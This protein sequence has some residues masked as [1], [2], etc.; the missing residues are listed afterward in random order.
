MASSQQEAG[1]EGV[2][3]ELQGQLAPRIPWRLVDPAAPRLP[4]GMRTTN[5]AIAI[6]AVVARGLAIQALPVLPYGDSYG[7]LVDPRDL[8]KSLW[9]PG[10]QTTLAALSYVTSSPDA[11]RA[12]TALQGVAAALAAGALAVAVLGERARLLTGLAVAVLPTFVLTST[13]L[14]QE[15]LFLWAALLGLARLP[16]RPALAHGLVAFA[17]L[18]RYEAWVIA[19]VLALRALRRRELGA[20]VTL[21]AVPVLWVRW[22]RGV[23]PEGVRSLH[24]GISLARLWDRAAILGQLV[25]DGGAVAIGLT[26]VVGAFLGG[27]SALLLLGAGL[28]HLVWLAVLDPYSAPDHPRQAHIPLVILALLASIAV[29]RLPHPALRVSAAILLLAPCWPT[30][31]RIPATYVT[32]TEPLANAA[33]TALRGTLSPDTRAIVLSSGHPSNPTAPPDECLAVRAGA[34][35]T[36]GD[37]LCDSDST[38]P[39]LDDASLSVL[40]RVGLYTAWRPA[41]LQLHSSVGAGWTE[42]AL[43]DDLR[44]WARSPAAAERIASSL[45]TVAQPCSSA[46]EAPFRP[47]NLELQGPLTLREHS[48]IALYA[49][50]GVAWV[51]PAAGHLRVW[52]C[53]TPAGGRFPR[54]QV[55]TPSGVQTFETTSTVR[56]QDVG[57][58]EA[59]EAVQITFQDDLVDDQGLDRNVFIAGW[60]VRE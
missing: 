36:R 37:I 28:I 35:D 53:G 43:R 26:A 38:L 51:A 11:F 34:R 25:L 52:L 7:R 21:L 54:V 46:L 31:A 58:V 20:S 10:Y 41:E 59:G 24:L 19:A 18:V 33:G 39:R 14:Y 1:D 45:S 32:G 17:C 12:W 29:R 42:V 22:S 6:V 15:P 55:Q 2:F 9:L 50:G 47:A 13:G 23:S 16:T 8:V 5:L 60:Q 49:N 57:A 48:R 44:I 3:H 27:R 30:W 40:V 4:T 56:A